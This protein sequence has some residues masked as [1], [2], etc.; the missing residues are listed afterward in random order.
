MSNIRLKLQPA[1]VG[2]NAVVFK[3]RLEKNHV[4]GTVSAEQVPPPK[5]VNG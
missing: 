5:Q 2:I 1:R 3:N 4:P